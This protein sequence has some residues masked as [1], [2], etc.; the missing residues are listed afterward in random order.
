MKWNRNEIN[1][2][3][4]ILEQVSFDLAPVDGK[5]I[6]VLCSATGEVAF[7]LGEMMEQGQVVGLELDLE[8]LDIARRSIHEMGLEQVVQFFPADK[9]RITLPDSSYDALLSEFIVYPTSMPTEIG[10]AEM[11]RVLKPGGKIVLT[12]VIAT[13]PIPD[14]ARQDLAAIGLDYIYDATLGDYRSWMADSGLINIEV[15]DLTSTVKMV[16]EDRAD[17]DLV[18]S[19][20]AGYS[21]LLDNPQGGL[22]K[23]IFYIYASGEKPK[24]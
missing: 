23:A 15:R 19:H 11:A 13:R 18:I 17:S 9:D 1:R 12:D 24:N 8:A 6:L 16:W 21:Y 4:S 14:Y 20:Q 5:N 3:L 10:Q 7:W 2:L 22:G